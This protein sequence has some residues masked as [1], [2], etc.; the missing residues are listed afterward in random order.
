MA[1]SVSLREKVDVLK[2]CVIIPTYNNAATL[3]GVIEDVAGYIDQII[4]VNDGSTDNT[5]AII[6]SFNDGRIRLINQSNQGVAST[7]NKG[8]LEAKAGYIA[9]FDADDIC[10][11]L[12]LE[13]QYAFLTQHPDYVMVGS[14]AEYVDMNGEFV[15]VFDYLGYT[16]KEIRAVPSAICSFS[17][18]TVMYKKDIIITAG[19]YDI[20]A[21]NFEDHLLW[22]KV[23]RLG[24]VFNIKEKLVTYRFNPQ[25]VTIDEKWRGRRFTKLKQDAIKKGSISR[26]DGDRLLAIIR[27]QDNEKIKK[28]SYHSLLSKKYLFNNYDRSKARKNIKSL[29]SI[30]PLKLQGYILLGLSYFPKNF[31]RS[32]YKIK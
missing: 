27:S 21:H 31:L 20:N 26:E 2:A 17:H 25:S 14:D 9:R 11:P 13:K 24:K 6:S 5:T 12:R 30:Y 4:V 19:M 8:L 3:A 10:H 7:L 29:I 16:D 23:I 1:G 18:P 28:G 22:S 32:L 15:F